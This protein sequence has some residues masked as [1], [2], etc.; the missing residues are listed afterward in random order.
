M[1][2]RLFVISKMH[3]RMLANLKLAI[4]FLLQY[5][6][7]RMFSCF[8]RVVVIK[9]CSRNIPKGMGVD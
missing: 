1:A 2:R 6:I 9:G 3:G 5:L 8:L 7:V 4:G